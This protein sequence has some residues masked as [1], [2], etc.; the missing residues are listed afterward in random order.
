MTNLDK[1]LSSFCAQSVIASL[2]KR[3]RKR[4]R[5]TKSCSSSQVALPF[6]FFKGTT[7]FRNAVHNDETIDD[8]HVRIS[9]LILPNC[10]RVLI[11]TFIPPTN[12]SWLE[13]IWNESQQQEPSNLVVVQHG[14][15]KVGDAKMD[16]IY[17]DTRKKAN[18]YTITCQPHN[19][20]IMHAKV[21]LFQSFEGLRVVISGNNFYQHQ[22]END[23]DCLWV[24]DFSRNEKK[25]NP[26]DC[27]TF[28]LEEF[29]YDLCQCQ[30]GPDHQ[31][32]RQ[33]ICS[34]F[35][36]IDISTVKASLVYSFPRTKDDTAN[37]GGWQQLQKVVQGRLLIDYDTD[38]EEDNCSQTPTVFSMSG[39]IGDVEPNFLLGMQN[40]ML[41]QEVY[42][43]KSITWESINNIQCLMISDKTEQT[44]EDTASNGRKMSRSHWSLNIPKEAKSRLFNDAIHNNK[45]TKLPLHP[46]VHGKVLFAKYNAENG[47]AT[48]NA[49]LYVGSHNFS[50]AAW[51]VANK[52]PNNIEVGVVLSSS[53]KHIQAEW[54]DRLPYLLPKKPRHT[55][56]N[57]IPALSGKD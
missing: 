51:G 9:N 23:R 33:Y 45:A 7:V 49:I 37:C 5:R 55:N 53:D 28:P 13:S 54:E 2:K 27:N 40:A 25:K 31:F 36:E 35:K 21:Y 8:G 24:Q 11:T 47:S 22:W 6:G 32:M 52:M 15:Y 17:I 19:G 26:Y 43:S 10:S 39:S 12:F 57:F 30:G 38:R 14:P 56:A 1:E 3:H 29:L 46:F 4:K 34:M 41:G 18:W 44:I 48:G 50:K 16:P 42:F 20:G